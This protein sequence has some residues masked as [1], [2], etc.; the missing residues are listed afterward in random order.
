MDKSISIKEAAE[1]LSV[2][3]ATIRRKIAGGELTAFKV[4]RIW[5]IREVDLNKF[6]RDSRGDQ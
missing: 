6:I 4:G 2:H 3:P 5:R 1:A